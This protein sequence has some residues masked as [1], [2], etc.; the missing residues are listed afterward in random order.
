[1]AKNDNIHAGHR[2]RML[3]K[4]AELGINAFTE[5]E[6]LEV[7]LFLMIPRRNTNNIAHDLIN[8]FGSLK[9]VLFAPIDELERIDGVGKNT[10]ILLRLIGALTDF[11]NETQVSAKECFASFEKVTE[12]CVHHLKDKISE[13]ITLLLLDDKYS[14]LH[15]H[16]MSNNKPNH[17]VAKSREII[18]QIIKYECRKIIIAHNH[19]TGTAAPSDDDLMNTRKIG[20]LLKFVDVGLVD[21][22]IV[23]KDQAFSMRNSGFL[24]EIWE[25]G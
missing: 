24:N 14:L 5:H 7:L 8:E 11:L 2:A 13:E 19:L 6:K 15:V 1:M 25:A 18:G 4:F 17:I 12:Y 20:E 22:I 10:A 23:Y 16:D 9:S 3:G 21:H